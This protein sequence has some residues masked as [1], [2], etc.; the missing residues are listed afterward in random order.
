[1]NVLGSKCQATSNTKRSCD[2]LSSTPQ[3]IRDSSGLYYKKVIKRYDFNGL[4]EELINNIFITAREEGHCIKCHKTSTKESAIKAFESGEYTVSEFHYK[5][6]SVSGKTDNNSQPIPIDIMHDCGA[7]S[8]LDN[9]L[10]DG[11]QYN[12]YHKDYEFIHNRESS[13]AGFPSSATVH[14]KRYLAESGWIYTGYGYQVECFSCNGKARFYGDQEDQDPWII[15]ACFFSDCTYLKYMMGDELIKKIRKYSGG[16]VQRDEY[17]ELLED[18]KHTVNKKH[19]ANNYVSCDDI[20]KI[21]ALT[22]SKKNPKRV[23][24]TTDIPYSPAFDKLGIRISSYQG[25]PGYVSQTPKEMAEAGWCFTGC[26]DTTFCF[27]CNGIAKDWEVYHD[28]LKRHKKLYPECKFLV[29]KISSKDS[30]KDG[31]NSKSKTKDNLVYPDYQNIHIRTSSYQGWPGYV[32]QTPKEM[33]E[34]GWFYTGYSDVTKCF[35]CGGTAKQWDLY[36]NPLK[37]HKELY[38]ECKFLVGKVDSKPPEEVNSKQSNDPEEPIDNSVKYQEDTEDMFESWQIKK[39]LGMGYSRDQVERAINIVIINNIDT[40]DFVRDI[41][42]CIEHIRPIASESSASFQ[43]SAN[44]IASRSSQEAANTVEL[45]RGDKD[46]KILEEARET[47]KRLKSSM[48]CKICKN[49]EKK[50]MFLPCGHF[51]SCE[52]CAPTIKKCLECNKLVR[53]TLKTYVS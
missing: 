10:Y 47:N 29:G 7:E 50:I 27:H 1:M 22:I 52:K 2:V 31:G 8:R 34:A 23:L 11:K 42:S 49:S 5:G 17:L 4:P 13:F 24:N 41:L 6:C 37:R 43:G 18:V 25:W 30:I 53:E 21:E 39:V 44:T 36:T 20:N 46:T 9:K 35:Q 45:S 19:A 28:P 38:P 48:L 16:S 51:I 26:D 15:H 12:I 32:S 3:Y 33:A 14:N 40:K